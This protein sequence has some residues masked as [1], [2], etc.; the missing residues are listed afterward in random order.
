MFFAN[1]F[2]L[3]LSLVMVSFH[4]IALWQ[5][6]FVLGNL[7]FPE[8]FGSFCW[9]YGI[10]LVLRDVNTDCSVKVLPEN[11]QELIQFKLDWIFIRRVN[12][13]PYPF[14]GH[15]PDIESFWVTAFIEWLFLS[16]L[17]GGHITGGKQERLWRGEK[18]V[19]H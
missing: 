1:A 7:K 8:C 2:G 19:S 4:S 18:T 15:E 3:K 9:F 13:L 6:L 11:S 5:L 14:S 12:G 17:Q 10:S 16:V